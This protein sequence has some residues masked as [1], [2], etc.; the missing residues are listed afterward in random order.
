[1]F[2]SREW[3][4]RKHPTTIPN[5]QSGLLPNIRNRKRILFG[6]ET[7]ASSGWA[8]IVFQIWHSV[9]PW[10]VVPQ[11][12]VFCIWINLGYLHEETSCWCTSLFYLVVTC[13][14]ISSSN[15]C[16]KTQCQECLL[17][18]EFVWK[19]SNVSKWFNMSG[20]RVIIKNK[21]SLTIFFV[22]T[23]QSFGFQH[24]VCL[25]LTQQV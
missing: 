10:S 5:L 6:I 21:E 19:S 1:M 22:R 16:C 11:E 23:T 3:N 14:P 2:V 4:H 13:W 9:L 8:T 24:I 12:Y 25:S 20:N 15:P 7:N 18:F 17:L